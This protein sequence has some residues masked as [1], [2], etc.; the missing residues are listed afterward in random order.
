MV[1]HDG[2]RKWGPTC[3]LGPV[4]HGDR[5]SRQ[6]V[7]VPGRALTSAARCAC[8]HWDRHTVVRHGERRP[9]RG[10]PK[11]DVSAVCAKAS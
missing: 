8:P 9:L 11:R 1:G 5:H 7:P 4:P 3:I 6:R 10:R 2:N